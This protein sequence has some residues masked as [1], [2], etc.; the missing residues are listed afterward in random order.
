L[1]REHLNAIIID[2]RRSTG[3]RT[4]NLPGRVAWPL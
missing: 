2:E 4:A 1:L 3:K